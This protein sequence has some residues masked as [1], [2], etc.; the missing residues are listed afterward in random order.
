MVDIA[1]QVPT[2][3]KVS[4]AV[5]KKVLRHN[6]AVAPCAPP[7]PVKSLVEVIPHPGDGAT[8]N[9]CRY[10]TVP[11]LLINEPQPVCGCSMGCSPFSLPLRWVDTTSATAARACLPMHKC[12]AMAC[13]YLSNRSLAQSSRNV[14]RAS[15]VA[16]VSIRSLN[17]IWHSFEPIFTNWAETPGPAP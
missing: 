17:P 16:V 10:D 7:E 9:E 3:Y 12:S 5:H 15:A 14:L 1:G 6:V 4:P 13:M 2:Q 11:Y 8:R